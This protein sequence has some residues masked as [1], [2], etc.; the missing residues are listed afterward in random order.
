[1]ESEGTLQVGH[2]CPHGDKT[3]ADKGVPAVWETSFPEADLR[4]CTTFLTGF[5]IPELS[6]ESS[7]R[8]FLELPH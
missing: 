1:M 8:G 2:P 4:N 3:L 5:K 6:I 7:S